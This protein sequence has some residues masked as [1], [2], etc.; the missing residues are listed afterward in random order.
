MATITGG[1][2]LE[3]ELRRLAGQV[4]KPAMLRVGF[5]EGARYPDGTPVAMVAA[6]DEF[7]APSR[8]QPPRPAFRNMIAAKS[9]E[10]PAAVAGL[11]KSNDY[12]AEKTLQLAGAAIAG[13]L[14]QSI[15]TITSPPLKPATIKRKGFDKPWIETSHLLNSVDFEVK[16]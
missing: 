3:A 16:T 11:L 6:I 2:K 8:G 4:A 5:L 9:G 14:R 13:Q 15:S 12:D 7:G 10:W 1:K